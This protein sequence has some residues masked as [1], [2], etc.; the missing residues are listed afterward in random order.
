[1]TCGKVNTHDNKNT[2]NRRRITRLI[3][4]DKKRRHKRR[5]EQDSMIAAFARTGLGGRSRSGSVSPSED[6]GELSDRE[7]R[8][9]HGRGRENG[10]IQSGVWQQQLEAIQQQQKVTPPNA[11]TSST[12]NVAST[13]SAPFMEMQQ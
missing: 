5:R 1:M 2:L 8:A 12:A 4:E 6:S 10:G 13:S 11:T 9:G 3:R 7:D